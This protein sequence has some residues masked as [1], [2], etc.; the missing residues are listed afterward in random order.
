MTCPIESLS[1]KNT[2]CVQSITVDG[3]KLKEQH[4]YHRERIVI[5]YM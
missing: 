4:D 2:S 3:W 1:M 5:V